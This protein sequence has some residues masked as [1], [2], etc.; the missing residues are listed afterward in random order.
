M[1]LETKT[2]VP[3]IFAQQQ[4]CIN[5]IMLRRWKKVLVKSA[6]SLIL[7]MANNE[8]DRYNAIVYKFVGGKRINFS[9]KNSYGSRC[10]AA[11]VPFNANRKA[12]ESYY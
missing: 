11:T 3:I 5:Q 10:G 8:A 7:N 2:N 6:Q 1:Y 9:T 12:D 4:P